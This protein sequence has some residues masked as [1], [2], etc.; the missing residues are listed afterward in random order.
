[1][2]GGIIVLTD[3]GSRTTEEGVATSGDNDTLGFTL[4]ASRTREALVTGLLALGKGLSSQSSLIDRNVDGL[5]KTAIGGDD[6]TNLE[7]NHI[8]RDEICRVDFRP[9]AIAAD[10]GLGGERVHKRLDGVTSVAFFVETNG[11]VD[12]EQEDDTDKI[13]PVRCTATTVRQSD[14]DKGGTL[15]DPGE[16][17]PHKAQELQKRIFLFGFKPV[18]TEQLKTTLGLGIGETLLGTL[19]QSKD[20]I[21][22]D[23]FKIDL[24]LVVQILSFELDLGK[25]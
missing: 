6:I 3:E 2:T 13:R 8:T 25:S 20:I 4:F 24:V 7:R 12:Q 14:G 22:N 19:E 17:I 23:G 18:W 21:E 5:G 1:V 10:L 9:F 11:R 16:R 15:H